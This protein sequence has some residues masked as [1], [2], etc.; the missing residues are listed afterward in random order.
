MIDRTILTPQ[1]GLSH[2]YHLYSDAAGL[3]VSLR[4]ARPGKS[5]RV[6]RAAVQ[7]AEDGFL[8]G[9][10]VGGTYVVAARRSSIPIKGVSSP[11]R[12]SRGS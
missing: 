2:R 9:G 5:P 4:D 8:S 1:S 12:N 3:S 6:G 11:A 7:Y 10:H